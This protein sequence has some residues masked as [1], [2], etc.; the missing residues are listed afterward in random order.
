MF[1]VA[2][3]TSTSTRRRP[4]SSISLPTKGCSSQGG[5]GSAEAGGHRGSGSRRPSQ[6]GPGGRG[7]PAGGDAPANPS[8]LF[9]TPR[10][11]RP[12][13]RGGQEGSMSAGITARSAA[14]TWVTTGAGGSTS[15]PR[16][17]AATDGS[18]AVEETDEALGH[19]PSMGEGFDKA[20][21]NSENNF[22]FCDICIEEIR[23]GNTN[24]G[25]MTNR[26]YKNI[27]EKYHLSTG[28]KHSLKQLKNRW[29]QLK[30]LPV[31]VVAQQT[32][33]TRSF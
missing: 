1:V 13:T 27:A 12:R 26:G 11:A 15:T 7:P 32:D 4:T 28:L 10:T 6:S 17:T 2:T 9:R 5:L 21:W 29:G 23:A 8:A 3:V 31:L 20:N 24:N 30:G 14:P 22:I 16:A 19:E 33:W 18:E 25:F